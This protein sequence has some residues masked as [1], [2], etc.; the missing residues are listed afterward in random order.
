M[1]EVHVYLDMTNQQV[2]NDLYHCLKKATNHS[3]WFWLTTFQI[4]YT[5]QLRLGEAYEHFAKDLLTACD[6][7]QQLAALP[8]AFEEPVYGS[9]EP[10]FTEF[11]APGVILS[12]TYFMAVGLT[13]LSFIRKYLYLLNQYVPIFFNLI[14]AN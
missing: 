4:G 7:P 10:T 1:S 11:M 5:I 8:I 3:F 12:I 13:A 6:I 9:I 2:K 14:S